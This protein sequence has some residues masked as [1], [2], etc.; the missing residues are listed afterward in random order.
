MNQEYL[1]ELRLLIG[2]RVSGVIDRPLGSR[3]PK[4]Q[5]IIYN[6]NYGYLSDFIAPDGEGQDVYVLGAETALKTFEG[7]VI[8]IIERLDDIECKLVVAT[9]DKNFGD[10]EIEELVSFQEQYFKHRIIRK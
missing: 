6:V 2:T 8:A 10:E 1:V 9:N 5:N 3:H 4:H 7:T